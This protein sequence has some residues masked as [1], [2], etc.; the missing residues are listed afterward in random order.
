MIYKFRYSNTYTRDSL[1]KFGQ[2]TSAAAV[3][4]V[5]KSRCI[6]HTTHTRAFIRKLFT[7]AAS[8]KSIAY[9]YYVSAADTTNRFSKVSVAAAKRAGSYIGTNVDGF[10]KH[11]E[12]C[13]MKIALVYFVFFIFSFVI[14]SLF[15]SYYH[16]LSVIEICVLLC[17]TNWRR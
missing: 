10:S 11:F 5:T 15:T 4:T 6:E 16:A 13:A 17:T 3:G 12:R 8:V 14:S 7:L 2:L 1:I 9:Y